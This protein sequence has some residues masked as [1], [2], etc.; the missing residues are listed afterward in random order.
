[1]SH[2]DWMPGVWLGPLPPLRDRPAPN[3]ARERMGK[4]SVNAETASSPTGFQILGLPLRRLMSIYDMYQPCVQSGR[5]RAEIN[6]DR[7]RPAPARNW[8]LPTVQPE[9]SRSSFTAHYIPETSRFLQFQSR[10]RGLALSQIGGMPV[11][12]LKDLNRR[13]RRVVFWF[14]T[15][16]P[17]MFQAAK[18]LAIELVTR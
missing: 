18:K 17:K 7:L 14:E 5:D 13:S 2:K 10:I 15:R 4:T 1:V 3:Y 16:F 11:H 12:S 8:S 9:F 6:T